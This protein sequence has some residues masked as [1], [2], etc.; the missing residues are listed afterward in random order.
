MPYYNTYLSGNQFTGYP[1]TQQMQFSSQNQPMQ[2][3]NNNQQ[4]NYTNPNDYPIQ[5]VQFATEAE[6]NAFM[7]FPNTRVMFMDR[8]NNVFW[9]K[10]ADSM[11]TA[12]ME[13]FEFK[14]VDNNSNNITQEHNVDTSSFVKQED[15]SKLGFVTEDEFNNS[16][17]SIQDSLKKD[18]D[19]LKKEINL[20]KIMQ[21][22]K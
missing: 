19:V 9:I 17:K 16:L 6:V 14:R 8:N 22:D 2:Q 21:E 3:V 13:K 5:R 10:W 20:K 15:L 1:Q 18:I 11:G 4:V 12:G 7:P